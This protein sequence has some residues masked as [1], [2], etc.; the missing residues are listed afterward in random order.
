M[1]R[2]P[3]DLDEYLD[4]QTRLENFEASGLEIDVFCL[5]EGVSRSTFYRWKERLKGG[6]PHALV[7]E[8]EARDRAAIEVPGRSRTLLGP[9]RVHAHRLVAVPMTLDLHAMR[10]LGA[11]AI[12]M[13]AGHPVL[14]RRQFA[15]SLRRPRVMPSHVPAK[16]PTTP[17]ME[18]QIGCG[19]SR[20]LKVAPA[21]IMPPT[22]ST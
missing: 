19:M 15:V 11:A 8:N 2:P 17:R 14:D 10:I 22:T 1:G 4:W 21:N 20:R 3:S 18:N 13:V 16:I 7:A 12:T 6:I 5:Q 9:G